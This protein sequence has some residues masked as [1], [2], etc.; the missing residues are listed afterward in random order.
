VGDQ[1]EAPSFALVGDPILVQ[2]ADE[3]PVGNANKVNSGA[4]YQQ[5]LIGFRIYPN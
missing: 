4:G 2:F 1:W 3:Q 5:Y